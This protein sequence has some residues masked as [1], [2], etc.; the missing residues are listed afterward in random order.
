VSNSII[1]NSTRRIR[2]SWNEKTCH[3]QEVYLIFVAPTDALRPNSDA[4][5]KWNRE[6]HF[7]GP[8][9]GDQKEN[10][11]LIKS[12]LDLCVSH[13]DDECRDTH[14]TGREFKALIDETYFGVIDVADLQLKS[15]PTDD[16]GRPEP[17]VALSYVW[18]RKITMGRDT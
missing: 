7:L 10:Q 8:E 2:L 1:V 14:G 6:T 3:V 13:H 11:A 15:L 18:A 17:Y 5:S 4:N 12:W 16:D 9:R